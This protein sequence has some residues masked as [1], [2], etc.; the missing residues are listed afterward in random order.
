MRFGIVAFVSGLMLAAFGVAMLLPAV[1]DFSYEGRSVK[2]F[3]Q[4]A[5]ITLFFGSLL[6]ASSYNRWQNISIKETF[7]TTSSVWLAVV[8]FAALPFYLAFEEMNY[9]T[10]FFEAMSGLT[11]T[12]S[13]AFTGLDAMPKGVLLWRAML[14]WVGGIGIVM[15]AIVLL[16]MLRVGGM[17]MF[18]TESSSK[19]EGKTIPRLTQI[20]E[21]ILLIYITFSALCVIALYVAGMDIFDAVAHALTC[22]STGGFS[23]HDASIAYFNSPLIDWILIVF[24]IIGALPF[25]AYYYIVTGTVRR[26]TGDTQI[27]TFLFLIIIVALVLSLWLI[28]KEG[29]MDV[30]PTIRK[31]VFS[32]V[33]I[34][35]TTG[36]VLDDY[37]AWGVFALMLF[38]FLTFIGGCSGS[39][40]GGCKIFR[41][42]ILAGNVAR[43]LKNMIYPH[44][45]FTIK[46]NGASVSDDVVRGVVV[47][48]TIF[49]LALVL[50][51]LAL[52]FVGLDFMTALT[53]ALASLTN[54]GPGLGNIIGPDG[55]FAT[56]PDCAKWLLSAGMMLGRLEFTT[57]MVL[58]V[59][60]IWREN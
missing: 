12:G 3:L 29:S 46:Y 21:F 23:T 50:L 49:V 2:A 32:V 57:V 41:F 35:T 24:M 10:A 13:T 14:Q 18:L 8:C 27:K 45:V 47:F 6:A 28:V 42:N 55:S 5:G 11:S 16:P 34:V 39:S 48:M 58:F 33:S 20:I 59:P 25:I 9:A 17:Q 40:A 54:V 31:A 30:E 26:F 52:A 44:G 53:G 4:A 15:I 7:L 19:I 37:A 22:V 60:F 43:Y 56:L 1:V 38:F 51:T 36:Y